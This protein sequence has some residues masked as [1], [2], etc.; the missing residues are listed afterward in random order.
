MTPPS[1]KAPERSRRCVTCGRRGRPMPLP[2]KRRAGADRWVRSPSKR[3]CRGRQWGDRCAGDRQAGRS[4][5]GTIGRLRVDELSVGR[6]SVEELSVVR[7]HPAPRGEAVERM[8]QRLDGKRSRKAVEPP[9]GS[10]IQ[11]RIRRAVSM[12]G[13]VWDIP[14]GCLSGRYRDVNSI[15]LLHLLRERLDHARRRVGRHARIVH[16]VVAP[17]ARVLERRSIRG[18][19]ARSPLDH[20][21]TDSLDLVG[22]VA[23]LVAGRTSEGRRTLRGLDPRLHTHPHRCSL[24]RQ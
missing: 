10:D 5:R 9:G 17:G 20:R 3:C 23:G 19:R 14:D 8:A 13:P 4:R 11:I 12:R 24:R 21:R 15:P 1:S 22:P 6:L 18:R 7:R 2:R 16:G